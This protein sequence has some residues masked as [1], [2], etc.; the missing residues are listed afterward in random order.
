MWRI[1]CPDYRH[2]SKDNIQSKKYQCSFCA[3]ALE[4]ETDLQEF[5]ELK[6]TAEMENTSQTN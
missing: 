2:G 1:F 4:F 5:Q 3:N 6:W